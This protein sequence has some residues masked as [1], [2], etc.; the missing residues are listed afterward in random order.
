[1]QEFGPPLR[2]RTDRVVKNIEVAKFMLTHPLRSPG[3]KSFIGGKS[4]RNQCTERLFVLVFG[5]PRI[6]RCF[7]WISS[8]CFVFSCYV[9]SK[10]QHNGIDWESSSDTEALNDECV[11]TL[12][13]DKRQFPDGRWSFNHEKWKWIQCTLCITASGNILA[14]GNL[15]FRVFQLQLKVINKNILM[16]LS[17]SRNQ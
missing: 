4:C 6:F 8:L 1:M 14:S 10:W 5:R 17:S 16:S 9:K 13:N 3:Q 12:P 7:K 15:C 2:V 11:N